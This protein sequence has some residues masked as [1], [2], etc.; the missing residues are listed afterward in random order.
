MSVQVHLLPA[1]MQAPLPTGSVGVVIDILRASTTI[2]HALGHG[3]SKVI[4]CLTVEDALQQAASL[5]ARPLLGG[6][7]HAQLIPGFDLDNSPLKYAA[8]AVAGR[9]IVFTTT[10]GTRAL[11]QGQ[12]ADEVLVGGFVNRAAIVARLRSEN[13]PVH[14]ICAGTDGHLTGEDILFAGAVVHDLGITPDTIETQ[15]ALDFYRGHAR[16][17]EEFRQTMYWSR[18]G[19][20]LVALGL[21]ADIDRAMTEDLF[22]VVP[23]WNPVRNVIN[24]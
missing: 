5:P 23:V 6:E 3:A 14:L 4:P 12:A 8:D 2:I 11:Q 16:T 17:P 1:L 10:N 21:Q 20:N 15:L 7:R 13:R 18:G 19:Q 24:V 22:S 9:T